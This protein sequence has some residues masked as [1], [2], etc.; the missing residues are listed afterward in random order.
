MVLIL[1]R[2]AHEGLLLEPVAGQ[3]GVG[4]ISQAR[5]VDEQFG[6]QRRGPAAAMAK[7]VEVAEAKE[8]ESCAVAH[9]HQAQPAVLSPKNSQAVANLLE[10]PSLHASANKGVVSAV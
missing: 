2:Q 4:N 5:Y 7:E 6:L 9:Q 10:A 8:S 1:L 3:E